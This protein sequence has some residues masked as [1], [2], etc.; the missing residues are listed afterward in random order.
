MG[1]GK[2]VQ[3]CAILSYL[4]HEMEQYG[5]FLVVVPLSTLP[6][7]QMQLGQWAPDLNVIPYIGN[8]KSREIIRDYEFGAPKKMRFNVLLTTYEFALKD[9][10]EFGQIK[11]QYIMVDEAHR[12]KNSESQLYEALYSLSTAA[13]LLITGTPLQ[14]NVRGAFATPICFLEIHFF[15]AE[16]LSLMHFLHPERYSLATDFELTGS[17]M[18]SLVQK[19]I[20]CT[21]MK[22][23]RLK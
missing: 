22:T 4:F 3:S 1:L 17:F 10:A 15:S 9:K 13:K 23:T 5:P 19:L 2:T 20:P 8:S 18:T 11:W 16:L 7:W 14:N 21:Q 12:L 6:A